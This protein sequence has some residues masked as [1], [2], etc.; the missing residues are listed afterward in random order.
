MQMRLTTDN[1][2]AAGPYRAKDEDPVDRNRL[3]RYVL[4]KPRTQEAN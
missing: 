2:S 3:R 4:E 1:I